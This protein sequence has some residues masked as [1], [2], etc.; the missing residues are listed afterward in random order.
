[1]NTAGFQGK[2][3]RF[4]QGEHPWRAFGFPKMANPGW[5]YW[6]VCISKRGVLQTSTSCSH[7][8]DVEALMLSH[9][10]NASLNK[11]INRLQGAL[12]QQQQQHEQQIKHLQIEHDAALQELKT[13]A[14]DSD[15][16]WVSTCD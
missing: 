4:C 12:E 1:M 5:Q 14:A 2:S 8:A 3:G 10:E 7:K 6:L 13:Q 11:R 15:Q 16:A 9:R